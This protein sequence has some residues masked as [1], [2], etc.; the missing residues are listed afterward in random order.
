MKGPENLRMVLQNILLVCQL[1]PSQFLFRAYSH[2]CLYK[3]NTMK[4]E[5]SDCFE[6]V[7]HCVSH[8]VSLATSKAARLYLTRLVLQASYVC[9]RVS[10]ICAIKVGEGDLLSV[11]A[12][13]PPPPPPTYTHPLFFD[14]F[15][16]SY[17][18]KQPVNKPRAGA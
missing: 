16:F 18:E 6:R 1:V 11:V 14:L 7:S 15:F 12:L 5:Q 4:Y 10:F 3:F 8:N 13:P 2:A 17:W 9:R